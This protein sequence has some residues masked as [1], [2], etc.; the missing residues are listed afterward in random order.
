MEKEKSKILEMKLKDVP[1][2]KVTFK[3]ERTNRINILK[4]FGM[5]N[6]IRIKKER[7]RDFMCTVGIVS[8]S[9]LARK[10]KYTRSRI[11]LMFCQER[12]STRLLARLCTVLGCQ[13][14]EIA[15]IVRK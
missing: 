10:T 7:L 15:E 11:S 6:M 4:G 3:N 12:V 2:M 5:E 1:G 8:Q 13:P 9:E 14:N